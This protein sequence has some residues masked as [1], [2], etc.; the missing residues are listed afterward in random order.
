MK[1]TVE[2]TK[3]TRERLN[4]AKYA[5]GEKT[6]DDTINKILDIVEKVGEEHGK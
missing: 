3:T 1:T 5:M 6:I 2:I 4:R